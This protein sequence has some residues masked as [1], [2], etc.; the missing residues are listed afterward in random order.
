MAKH[1]PCQMTKLTG[2][3]RFSGQRE[4]KIVI[5][6]LN[7]LIYMYSVALEKN[8][9]DARRNF[10]SSNKLDGAKEILLA[11][12]R[13]EILGEY[14][15]DRRSYKMKSDWWTRGIYDRTKND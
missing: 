2:I 7:L 4:Y 9:D 8:N 3:R 5:H 11:D 13:M 6:K 15:R 1:V 14:E 12:A 10:R